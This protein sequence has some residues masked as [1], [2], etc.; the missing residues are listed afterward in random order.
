MT[1]NEILRTALIGCGSIGRQ[2]AAALKQS[3]HVDLTYVIDI[4]KA[5]ADEFAAEFDTQAAYDAF[6]I[7]Q[8]NRV[9]LIVVSTPPKF[10]ADISIEAL[11]H[12]IHVLCE[13]PLSNTLE[14]ARRMCEAADK[15]E[16]FLKTGFNHRYF[17]SMAFVHELI[18]SGKIGDVIMLKAYAGHPGGAEFGPD[19][20]T[21]GRVTG[22]GSLFDNGIHILD[23]MRFFIGDIQTAK[24]Y[25]T[26]LI[27]EFDHAED[28]GFALFKTDK[29][30]I[31][32]L[33]SSWTNW[34]GYHFWVEVFGSRG[35]A[36]A[37][38]PPMIAEWG[39][40]PK[41]GI[42]S[43]RRFNLFP[44]F[45]IKERLYTWQWTIVQSFLQELEEFAGAIERG[46][47]LKPD[48]WDG[49][50]AMELAHAIYR[51][52]DEGIEVKV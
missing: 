16:G 11:E 47:S 30:Q 34:R 37:S 14:D 31:A 12:N 23:L 27:W 18:E 21:D 51:S 1:T 48:G 26:N 3:S 5:R 28:N 4:D 42:R 40:T 25:K 29:G 13:K 32:Q 45:Q 50:R 9:D 49:L 43:K 20:V 17:A 10:H 19:W 52:S 8:N 22:G 15:S 39:T 38:Y 6:E 24:G 7:V 44:I 41:H 46:E 36:R 2:R 33:H 35:Y